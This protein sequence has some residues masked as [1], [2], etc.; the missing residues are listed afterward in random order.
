MDDFGTGYT[1]LALLQTLPIDILKIDRA[2]SRDMLKDSDNHAIVRAI[3]SL[4]AALGMETTAEGI[5]SAALAEALRGLGCTYGQGFHYAEPMPADAA[6]GLLAGAQRLIDMAAGE[7]VH[8]LPL[9]RKVRRDPVALDRLHGA[10][11]R[12]DPATGPWR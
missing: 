8:R 1:S 9:R 5:E 4:A 6:L 7:L 3:L 12:S 10:R 11:R 2:S